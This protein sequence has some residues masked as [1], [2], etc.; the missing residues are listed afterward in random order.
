MSTRRTRSLAES[1][2]ASL[3]RTDASMPT[4]NSLLGLRLE[5]S[6][7]PRHGLGPAC[8]PPRPRRATSAQLRVSQLQSVPVAT[9]LQNHKV[10]PTVR[11]PYHQHHLPQK[12]PNTMQTRT[13]AL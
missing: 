5:R 12:G 4:T 11:P 3:R 6:G 8:S 9:A 1:A 13:I 2:E 10:S 7:A